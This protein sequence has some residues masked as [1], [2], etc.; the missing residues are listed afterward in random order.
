MAEMKLALIGHPLQHSQ[1]PFI[2]SFFLHDVDY[3][4][5]DISINDLN[6]ILTTDVIGFNVTIPYKQKIIP[7]LNALSIEAKEIGSVNVIKKINGQMMGYNTDAK[8]FS[9]CLDKHHFKVCNKH[10]LILGTGGVAKAVAYVLRKKGAVIQF[11]SRQKQKG[12]I[13][14]QEIPSFAYQAIVQ[15]TPVGLYPDLCSDLTTFIDFERCEWVVDVIANPIRTSF[16]NKAKC[17]SFGGIEMLVR[18]AAIADEIFT[19]IKIKEKQIQNCMRALIAKQRNIVLIGMAAVGKS[20]LAKCLDKNSLDMDEILSKEDNMSIQEIFGHKG[21]E[22][23][24]QRELKLAKKLALQYK[25]VIATGGGVVLN[26]EAMLALRANGILIWIK[27]DED[28]II[29]DD[30]RPLYHK[31]KNWHDIY[32]KRY[33]LYAK[34]ADIIIDNNN[35]IQVCVNKIKEKL[36]YNNI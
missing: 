5:L 13:T 6:T 2:H 18:Q 31:Q 9:E 30:K 19:H 12:M 27:R 15:C 10:I 29:L 34:Y 33:S 17:P 35:S 23:F 14:Y 28:K 21:E 25:K 26:D 3:Q 7:Y 16:L 11:V 20:T 24:R 1:S 8:A 4:L 36:K 32:H 22:Y